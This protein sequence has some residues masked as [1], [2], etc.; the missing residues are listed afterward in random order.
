MA[1]TLVQH[2]LH[3]GGVLKHMQQISP[4]AKPIAQATVYTSGT[5]PLYGS[6][7]SSIEGFIRGVVGWKHRWAAGILCTTTG[8]ASRYML[9]LGGCQGGV[10]MGHKALGEP[11]VRA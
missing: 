4:N 9:L 1:F 10:R 6:K 7:G 11:C 3:W 8:T 5:S 2:V